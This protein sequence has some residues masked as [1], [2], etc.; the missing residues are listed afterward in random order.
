MRTVVGDAPVATSRTEGHFGNSIVLLESELEEEGRMLDA[1]GRMSDEDLREVS[2]ELEMRIDDSCQLFLRFD[3]Q[4]AY[5]GDLALSGGDDVVAVRIK[6]RA[7]PAKR[8]AAVAIA[9]AALADVASSRRA[10]TEG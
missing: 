10:R 5:A 7:F 8:D 9:R 3:K 2:S 6:M 4:R 1:L